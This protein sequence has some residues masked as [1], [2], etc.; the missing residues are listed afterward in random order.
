MAGLTG[1]SLGSTGVFSAHILQSIYGIFNDTREVSGLV[2]R[3]KTGE[4]YELAVEFDFL[5]K[6][7]LSDDMDITF[8]WDMAEGF[9]EDA[10]IFDQPNVAY[11]V[12]AGEEDLRRLTVHCR[13]FDSAK[14]L[15]AR[16]RYSAEALAVR[17]TVSSHYRWDLNELTSEDI[18][19]LDAE[20][21]SFEDLYACANWIRR[22][23]KY[24]EVTEGPQ[25]AAETFRAKRGDCDDIAI[26]MCY[27]VG[28]LFPEKEPRVAEGWTTN[29][30][31][32]ANTLIHT[33]EG[34]I[35]LDPNASSLRFDV[36]DSQPF[37]PAGRVSLPFDVRDADGREAEP[38]ELGIAFGKGTVEKRER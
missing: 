23:I 22:N 15:T 9:D 24:E 25:S 20:M 2:L 35:T 30:R 16:L 37:V 7:G 14:G 38:G 10:V 4:Y 8:S 6:T 11:E 1:I 29:G 31:Y 5:N 3:D 27:M 13:G 18:S 28:R 21:A 33:D 19:E 36:L 32:H 12:G 34:W 17:E 26:L